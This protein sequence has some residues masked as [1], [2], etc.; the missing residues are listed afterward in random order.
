[1]TKPLLRCQPDLIL[2]QCDACARTAWCADCGQ[3][4]FLD[5]PL[6]P[7]ESVTCESCVDRMIGNPS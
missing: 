1:M 4:L 2:D 5:E 6:H 3:R 7:C